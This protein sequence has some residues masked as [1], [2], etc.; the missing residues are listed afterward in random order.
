MILTCPR[1]ASRYFVADGQVGPGGRRVRCAECAETWAAQP[2]KGSPALEST[3][4]A[5]SPDTVSPLFAAARPKAKGALPP[6][7]AGV[8][9]ALVLLMALVFVFRTELAALWPG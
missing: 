8:A 4:A 1:C 7:L 9:V 3:P 5:A 2:P 6:G